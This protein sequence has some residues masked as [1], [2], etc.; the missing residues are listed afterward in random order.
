M[1]ALDKN[2]DSPEFNIT[3]ELQHDR[4]AVTSSALYFAQFYARA[5]CYVTNIIVG[6]RSVASA[7]ALTVA[8]GHRTSANA[9][10]SV[11]AGSLIAAFISANSV[12]SYQTIT[13]NRTLAV[14]EYL[15]LQFSDP[16]GKY[17][18]TYEYQILP[19]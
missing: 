4:V 14:G 19:A 11:A 3:R 18:V 12:G 16:K 15:G 9:A 10:F 13:V 5:R 1:A 8:A 2:Y 6:V 17:H 7:A